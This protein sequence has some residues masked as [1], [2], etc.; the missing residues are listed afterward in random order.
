MEAPES[1]P[2]E[3]LDM[4]EH[5]NN[6]IKDRQPQNIDMD[7]QLAEGNHEVIDVSDVK[8]AVWIRMCFSFGLQQVDTNYN[9]EPIYNYPCQ[10]EAL[11][12]QIC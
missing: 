12:C 7:Y 11:A 6:A 10:L 3:V 5:K 4:Y 1:E 9:I 8:L 2:E